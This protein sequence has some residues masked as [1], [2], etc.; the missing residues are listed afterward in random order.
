[1]T[2]PE[3]PP[4]AQTGADDSAA[5]L[6]WRLWL[7]AAEQSARLA[8]AQSELRQMRDSKSWLLTAPLRAFARAIGNDRRVAPPHLQAP[9]PASEATGRA[10]PGLAEFKRAFDR[11][12]GRRL[13]VDVT[14]LAIADHGAGIQRV[15]RRLLAELLLSSPASTDVLPV[16]LADDGE[17]WVAYPFLAEFLGL[18]RDAAGGERRVAAAKGDVFLGLD[19]VREYAGPAH[20]AWRRMREQGAALVVVAYDVLPLR[21]PEWFPQAVPAQYAQW[22]EMVSDCADR[23]ASISA[24]TAD[25][26]AAELRSRGKPLPPRGISVFPLGCDGFVGPARE[27]L[28]RGAGGEKRVLM[29]GTIEPRKGHAQA[30]AAF[31]RMW[32]RGDQTELVIAGREGWDMSELMRSL[33]T[34]AE[35]GRRLHF[36]DNPDDAVLAGLYQSCDLLLMA[37]RGEGFGLPVVEGAYRGIGLMLRDLPVFREVA[38]GGAQYFSG[39]EPEA[40]VVALDRWRRG[41]EPLRGSRSLANWPTWADSANELLRVSFHDTDAGPTERGGTVTAKETE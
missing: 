23:V 38:G 9:Q 36:L 7:A 12:S 28:P 40:L 10:F 18:P 25:A 6:A 11:Q 19:F 8:E 14:A 17:Y 2:L 32:S 22:L 35:L 31:E 41:G 13:F 39:D 20:G 30:L 21:H 16:R 27:A 29:V 34:H 26:F 37:S 1:M 4:I 5:A 24:A 3:R 33:R 15:T